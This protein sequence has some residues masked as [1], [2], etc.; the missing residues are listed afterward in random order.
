M[1]TKIY[2][3]LTAL[4]TTMLV[5]A[6]KPW[7]LEQCVDTALIN[8]RNVKQK[9]L[10]N[11]TKDIAYQQARQNLL[12]DLNASASHNLGWGRALAD[13]NTYSN[14]TSLTQRTNYGFSSNLTLF[15]GLKMKYDIDARMADLKASE[16]D[17]EK[18]KHDIVM[19]V[20]SA[21]LQCLLNKELLQVA[22][23]QLELTNSKLKQRKLLV[24]NGK[25]AEGEMYELQAQASKEEL[26]R[27]QADNTLKLS[28]L[29]LAQILELN[30]FSTLDVVVPENLVQS[31][32][33]LLNPETVYSSALVH[34]PEVLNAQYQLQSSE[35]NVLIS[36]SGYYPELS[37]GASFGSAYYNQQGIPSK[38]FGEQL[39]D[40]IGA[41]I[42]FDLRIPI[43]NKFKTK[44]QVKT[45]EINVQN[46]KLMVENT[47]IELRKSI[48]QAYYNALAAK[49]KWDAAQKS[50]V[51]SREAYRFTNQKYENGRA[52]VYELFQAK[53]N[54]TQVLS[55][56]TQS[57]YEYVFRIKILELL[58]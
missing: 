11:K 14:S 53:S 58:K 15:D 9:V 30:D 57:K 26:N 36:K 1:K 2:I 45:A 5:S 40:K 34:R 50:E 6:Q 12:P 18:I 27:I 55:D 46:S 32:L 33:Q 52:T 37:L 42:G 7:T 29:D 20:S 56:V 22:T 39:S 31:E 4:F 16:A 8:N 48:Q 51:A 28:L 43:F 47:K 44:N 13:N 25:M 3:I 35:K 38:T 41:G 23:E 54:L 49:I 10:T 19:S 21:Y 24:E 17:V